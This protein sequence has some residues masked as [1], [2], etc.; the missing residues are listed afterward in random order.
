MSKPPPFNTNQTLQ[1]HGHLSGGLA[2]PALVL[3]AS[4]RS[5]TSRLGADG[6]PT[7]KLT[8]RSVYSILIFA[9]STTDLHRSVSAT[10]YSQNASSDT[11]QCT[12]PSVFKRLATSGEAIAFRIS[13]CSRCT[14]GSGKPAGPTIPYHAD[15]SKPGSVSAM[16]G[17]S[18]AMESR[19]RVDT[20][21][22]R[23]LPAR[24]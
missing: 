12:A 19:S 14:T 13:S 11:S 1:H 8:A 15:R 21:S 17:I 16:A 23:N 20:P 10:T 2:A 5:A 3:E 6:Q 18:G 9:A 22:A 24:T 7:E 4:T